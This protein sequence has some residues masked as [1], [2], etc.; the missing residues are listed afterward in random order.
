MSKAVALASDV[1]V[2]RLSDE[3]LHLGKIA[4]TPDTHQSSRRERPRTPLPA[5]PGHYGSVTYTAVTAYT[6]RAYANQDMRR[7][8]FAAAFACYAGLML[9]P[10][11]RHTSL[12]KFDALA[13][14]HQ[15]AT[16]RREILRWSAYGGAAA[17]VGFGA[18]WVAL[19]PPNLS[20]IL[21]AMS[22]GSSARSVF[23]YRNCAEARAAGVAP[24][25]RGQPGYR[26]G[27]DADNDGVACEPWR[28]RR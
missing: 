1:A 10:R 5:C 23:Y 27:L 7:C 13:R 22:S 14:K 8:F 15:R 26:P 17:I 6:G 11:Q 12:A 9:A 3:Y 18:M 24:I 28:G 2:D 21:P 19:Q 4:G 25:R 20:S 16:R